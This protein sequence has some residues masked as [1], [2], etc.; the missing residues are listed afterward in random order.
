MMLAT[1][2][3]PRE[4][5]TVGAR[6]K[7]RVAL[8]IEYDG[9]DFSGYQWQDDCRTVQGEVE[10]AILRLTG[11]GIRIIAASRTDAGVHAHGQVVSFRTLANLST[12]SFVSGLNHFL[13]GDI[14]VK[15]AHLL[16]ADLHVQRTAVSRRYEYCIV[17][18]LTRSPLRGRF[19]FVMRGGLDVA[20]MNEASRVLVGE[21]DFTSF[22][23]GTGVELKSPVRRV[24]SAGFTQTGDTTVFAIEANSFLTHQVR[25]TVGALIQVG[26]GRMSVPGFCSIME[27]RKPGLGGPMA[28]ACGLHLVRVNYPRPIE[29]ETD[30]DN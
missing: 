9:T 23:S 18:S 12:G 3:P 7:S 22:T 15:S 30:E 5:E 2:C 11:E 10:E 14:A 17:S 16:A 13:P 24:L 20:I 1:V 26:Q 29:E 28:P 8:V 19:A 21:H 27:Q 4:S 25:N 6:I